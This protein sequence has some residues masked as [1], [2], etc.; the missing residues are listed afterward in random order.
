MARTPAADKLLTPA[1]VAEQIQVA[2]KT[3]RN[4]RYL[5]RGPA[6]ERLT[7][8]TV[9]YR[10]SAVDCWRRAAETSGRAA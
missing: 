7:R 4:W 8:K 9:R 2:E 5:D 3:L 10:Q 6:F 1:E